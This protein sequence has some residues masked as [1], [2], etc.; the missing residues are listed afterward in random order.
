[1]MGKT[2]R[3]SLC[4]LG[5]LILVA[6]PAMAEDAAVLDPLAK[7]FCDTLHA[8][9][10]ARKAQCCGRAP[11]SSL[12]GECARTL[13][14]ALQTKAVRLDAA[15]LDRCA[16]AAAQELSGC[17][18][19]TPVMPRNPEVCRRMVQGDKAA[20]AACSSSLECKEGLFCRGG[21][22]TAGVC[23][24]PGAIGAPCGRAEDMLASYTRQTDMEIRHP[25]C[26]GFCVAGSCTGFVALGGGC[27]SSR[28]CAPGQHCGSGHCREGA[29]STSEE[30]CTASS[31]APDTTCKDGKCVALKA[32]GQPCTSPFECKA[33]CNIPQ[34]AKVGTCG[35]KCSNFPL[36]PADSSTASPGG[37]P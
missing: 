27:S 15:G 23:A 35:M 28:Q 13:S 3:S 16:K 21:G 25:E 6:L 1:M 18:W 34:G 24:A 30:T 37:N 22:S 4:S 20:G 26:T 12:A 11:S 5:F 33:A 31:C 8:L 10:E 14:A 2:V 29:F 19:V 32:A 9:P 36:L 17:D 7:Q